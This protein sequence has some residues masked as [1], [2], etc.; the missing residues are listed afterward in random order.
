MSALPEQHNMTAICEDAQMLL[1]LYFDAPNLCSDL[2]ACQVLCLTA[3]M[4]L[5]ADESSS[6]SGMHRLPFYFLPTCVLSSP[7]T[8]AKE[9]GAEELAS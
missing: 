6:V 2:T 1:D 7:H 4:Q 3:T 9:E 8:Q 5:H